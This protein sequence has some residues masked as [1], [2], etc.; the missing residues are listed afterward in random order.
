MTSEDQ[1]SDN[2]IVGSSIE[3]ESKIDNIKKFE[4]KTYKVVNNQI[5]KKAGQRLK[6]LYS[7]EDSIEKEK[8]LDNDESAAA[9]EP[10]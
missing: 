6:D 10:F 8:L 2:I 1:D 3:E 5:E 7:S 4:K 9:C